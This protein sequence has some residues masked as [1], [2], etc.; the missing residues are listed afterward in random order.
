M[1]PGGPAGPADTA[2][3]CAGGWTAA[4]QQL[5][6]GVA[7]LFSD[8]EPGKEWPSEEWL[9]RNG[10]LVERGAPDVLSW[11][12]RADVDPCG[13]GSVRDVCAI[14]S[15]TTDLIHH[16]RSEG[17]S[18]KDLLPYEN[19]SRWMRD[20]VVLSIVAHAGDHRDRD[21][22]LA[23]LEQKY[24][25]R[26]TRDDVDKV[27]YSYHHLLMRGVPGSFA[28]LRSSA[29]QNRQLLRRPGVVP[30]L[31]PTDDHTDEPPHELRRYETHAGQ[32]T[33]A[34]RSQGGAL[35]G[36][37]SRSD[38][39]ELPES[40]AADA[41]V[42]EQVKA[43]LGLLSDSIDRQITIDAWRR[44]PGSDGL[45]LEEDFRGVQVDDLHS[46]QEILRVLDEESQLSDL[47]HAGQGA[48]SDSPP[49]CSPEHSHTQAGC[50][51]AGRLVGEAP[52]GPE[53]ASPRHSSSGGGQGAAIRET[54][55]ET[56]ETDAETATA[57]DHTMGEEDADSEDDGEYVFV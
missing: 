15:T 19:L 34:S 42:M 51:S 24:P 29:R 6:Q 43:A 21:L 38:G 26:V 54:D 10:L 36:G 4:I 9:G 8:V 55:A 27:L 22:F 28:S 46:A 52:S 57:S 20:A 18:K 12:Q 53:E 14:L 13:D 3:I 44:L 1:A 5:R 40:H 49:Q 50:A 37:A 31:A 11:V 32:P 35:L 45:G 23:T 41:K 7:N 56:T 17:W 39:A 30:Q 48:A 16:G 25:R 47:Q 33:A 2:S